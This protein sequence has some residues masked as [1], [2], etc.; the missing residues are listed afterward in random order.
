MAESIIVHLLENLIPLLLVIVILAV[1][2]YV[3]VRKILSPFS[4]MG[5]FLWEKSTRFYDKIARERKGKLETQLH[6]LKLENSEWKNK[7]ID[8]TNAILE[9]KDKLNDL[10]KI[11]SELN[12]MEIGNVVMDKNIDDNAKQI[13]MLKT[14]FPS[15]L[16]SKFKTGMRI[17]RISRDNVKIEKTMEKNEKNIS[18]KKELIRTKI[19]EL[20]DSVY[21]LSDKENNP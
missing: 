20:Q 15:T 6:N 3:L 18:Y 11:F 1:V 10:S 16:F 8:N 12:E 21:K 9:I 13:D 4:A 19:D 2:L 7:Y 17:K 14:T 5:N